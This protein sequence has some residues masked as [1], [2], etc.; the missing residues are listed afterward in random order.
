MTTICGPLPLVAALGVAVL[1][2]GAMAPVVTR[3]VLQDPKA[4]LS[5]SVSMPSGVVLLSLLT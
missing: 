5:H 2:P 4:W 1:D 3:Y